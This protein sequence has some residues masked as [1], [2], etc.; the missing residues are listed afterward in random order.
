MY[1]GGQNAAELLVQFD[2]LHRARAYDAVLVLTDGSGYELDDQGID[3]PV[4]EA[5]VWMIHLGG[6]F[7]L[8]YDDST[9]QAIQASGG[10]V[11][12]DV[13]S[14][15]NRLTVARQGESRTPAA[16]R[17]LIDG[18][19]W[20]TVATEEADANAE[21]TITHSNSD[22]FAALAVRRL[23]LATMHEQR[24]DLDELAVLDHLHELAIEHSVVTPYSSM[25][26]L[27]N[28]RQQR[29][30]DELEAAGDRF[31]REY[32]EIGETTPQNA[33]TVTG[34]PEPEEWLLLALMAAMVIWYLQKTKGGWRRLRPS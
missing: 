7:P 31:Q 27:V 15:L 30:L 17:D 12:G 29:L 14:A 28:E 21:A 3:V 26:V 2:A 5:P 13:E 19:E 25:I 6:D 1:F 33:V 8:G 16:T 20:L 22:D 32:E 10:G 11:A 23:I 9:L 34:V 4:P 24:G 18:Y